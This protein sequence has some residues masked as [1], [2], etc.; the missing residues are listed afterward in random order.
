V[1]Y[2]LLYKPVV[3]VILKVIKRLI[4]FVFK[5][6]KDS[7]LLHIYRLDKIRWCILMVVIVKNSS[8]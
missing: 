6:D 7:M 5:I 4:L 3:I 1:K 8:S 2:K